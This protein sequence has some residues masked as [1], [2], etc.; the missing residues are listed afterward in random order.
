M[1]K[2]P[3][4]KQRNSSVFRGKT[5]FSPSVSTSVLGIVGF[6]TK[7]LG[8]SQKSRDPHAPQSICVAFAGRFRGLRLGTVIADGGVMHS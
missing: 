4:K 1:P 3:A 8:V 5:C 2:W 7:R 6:P